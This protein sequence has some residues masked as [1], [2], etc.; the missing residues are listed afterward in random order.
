MSD[1][2]AQLGNAQAIIETATRAADPVPLDEGKRFYSIALPD[3]HVLVDLERERTT[4]LDRPR[5]KTGTYKV[6]DADSFLAY[7]GKHGDQGTEVWADSVNAVLTGVLNANEAGDY[8]DAR[9]EDHRVVYG[10][11]HTDAW[12]AWIANDGRLLDQVS[13]AE[14]IEARSIDVIQPSAAEMLELAQTFQ[15]KTKVDFES[16]QLLSS[17]ERQFEFRETTDAKAGRK[18]TLSIP[19]EFSLALTPFEGAD[20]FKVKARFRYRIND[21]GLSLGYRLERPNDV[22]REAFLSV[23]TKVQS[24]LADDAYPITT[25]V[26]RGTR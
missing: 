21:G 7:I 2:L 5:R 16:S 3:G 11:Q 18:G 20:P 24:A 26:L 6:H 13:F 4:L 1:D 8:L 23:V 14:H 22:L 9:H 17:G 12:K 15:A 10:V 19:T 25:P